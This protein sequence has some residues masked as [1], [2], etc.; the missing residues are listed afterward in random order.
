M[1]GDPSRQERSLTRHDQVRRWSQ[2]SSYHKSVIILRRQVRTKS[3]D[4][5]QFRQARNQAGLSQQQAAAEL[6]VSQSYLSMLEKGQRPLSRELARRMVQVYE[7]SPAT[8]PS[9]GS[10]QPKMTDV[11]QLATDLAGLGYPGFAY[12]RT[13]R[14]PRNPSELL[15]SALAQDQLEARLFEALPW[16][17]LKYWEMDPEWVVQQ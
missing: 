6:G 9:Q 17:V 5:R 3:M 10:W 2:P 7:L 14:T 8:L 1:A 12:L 11:E 16:L 15:L 13:R 4:A